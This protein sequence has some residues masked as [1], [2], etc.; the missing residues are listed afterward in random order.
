[1][2]LMATTVFP[3]IN[4]TAVSL[5]GGVGLAAGLAGFGLVTLR[6]RRGAAAVTVI[7]ADSSIPKQQWTMPPLALLARPQWSTTRKVAML[8]MRGYLIV[9]VILLAV[10]AIQLGGG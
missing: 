10:K 8:T 2:I 7:E 1:L 9:S 4:V 5:G 6:S 3:N